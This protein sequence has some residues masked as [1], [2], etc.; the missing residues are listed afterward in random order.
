M[1]KTMIAAALAATA[2]LAAGIAATAAS[3][4]TPAETIAQ[5]QDNFKRMGRASKAIG[6]EFKK[7]A[8]DLAVIRAA[9]GAL[10]SLAPQVHRWFPRGT[11]KE[12][13]AKT[14][15][16]PAIWAQAPLFNT[17]AN[18]FTTA[19]RA[20]QQAATRGNIDQIKAAFPA[21]GGSCKGCHDTFKGD[22]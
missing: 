22:K 1:S 16:L 7:P 13:G 10:A 5:R 20:F 4:A 6:D 2:T 14:G 15:A 18:Q 8:P 12:S 11:G 19:A 17:K 21:V 9:S 3:A